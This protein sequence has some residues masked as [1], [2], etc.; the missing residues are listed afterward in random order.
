MT[1]D[2]IQRADAVRAT[3]T[4]EQARAAALLA[5]TT[6][7]KLKEWLRLLSAHLGDIDRDLLK[8]VSNEPGRRPD[9]LVV[10][11]EMML[12]ACVAD[13]NAYAHLVD[14]NAKLI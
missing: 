10:G 11:A 5:R 9:I 4:A 8:H 13:R 6:D 3:V 2:W 12:A 14:G 7:K 1:T